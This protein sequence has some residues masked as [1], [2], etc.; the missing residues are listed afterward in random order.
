MPVSMKTYERVALEDGD[1]LWELVC[2]RLREKPGMTADHNQTMTNAGLL[3][4]AQL[5]AN[6]YHIRINAGRMR[7]ETT[8]YI[9]DVMVIP[10]PLFEQT[11]RERPRGL[12]VYTEPLPLV[13]E[14]WS[15]ST[16]R[17]DRTQKLRFYQDRGDREIWLIHPYERWLRAWRRQPDGSYSE[18]LHTGDE[19]VEPVA[20]AGVRI[21]L[22]KLFA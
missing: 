1:G 18:T 4:A 10:T 5:D 15:P 22:A 7:R 3:I 11:R 13:V 20:L 8:A 14:V 2:G 19:T 6:T 17:R 16:G 12:E 21:E 9:P